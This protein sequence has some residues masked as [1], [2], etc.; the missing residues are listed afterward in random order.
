MVIGVLQASL[1]LPEARSL[2]DKRSVIRSLRDRIMHKMNISVAET[3][4]QDLWKA[5][6]MAFVTVASE[7]NVVEKRLA[8]VTTI[9]QTNPRSVLL[10]VHMEIL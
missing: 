5:A 2:K 8:E 9:L 3:G 10:D 6:E 4:K 1:S 7:K